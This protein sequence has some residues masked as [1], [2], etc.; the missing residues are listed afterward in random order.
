MSP[1]FW[2]I[3]GPNAPG[4]SDHIPDGIIS[5]SVGQKIL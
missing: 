1:D 5:F 2:I 3:L 4:F